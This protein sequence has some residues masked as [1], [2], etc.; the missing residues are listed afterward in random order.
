[1]ARL[2]RWDQEPDDGLVERFQSDPDEAVRRAALEALVDRW[3]GRVFLWTRRFV[4]ERETALDLAQEALL[5]M[6]GAL[7]RYRSSGRFG[8]WLFTIVHNR[9]RNAARPRSLRRDPEIDMDELAADV[10]LPESGL[11]SRAALQ[12]LLAGLQHALEPR[13]QAALWLRAAEGMSVEDIT[14]ALQI[15]GPSGARAVLQTAR[16]KLRAELLRGGNLE[17]VEP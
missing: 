15:D 14:R 13:E 9:C 10:P 4:R 6:I 11:D 5:A 17:G 8:A 1:M 2:P 12:R 3:S 7:P 16:R